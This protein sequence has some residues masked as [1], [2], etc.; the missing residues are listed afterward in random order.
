MVSALRRALERGG[1]DLDEPFQ[2][3][4]NFRQQLGASNA[5]WFLL[6]VHGPDLRRSPINR[7]INMTMCSPALPIL[8]SPATSTR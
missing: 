1:T 4:C 6:V 5:L 2:L 8:H 3:F 7:L